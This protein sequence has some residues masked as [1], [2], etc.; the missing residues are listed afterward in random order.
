MM[1]IPADLDRDGIE[2]YRREVER[3]LNRLTLEAEA[4][5]EAGTRKVNEQVALRERAGVGRGTA[6]GWPLAPP[7]TPRGAQAA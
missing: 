6:V 4:W 2:H 3:M 5:A 1:L 7:L